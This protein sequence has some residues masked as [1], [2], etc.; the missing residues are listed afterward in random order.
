MVSLQTSAQAPCP[1]DMSLIPV[2][3]MRS[4]TTMTCL[5]LYSHQRYDCSIFPKILITEEVCTDICGVDRPS[6][7][8]YLWQ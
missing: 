1:V 8:Y 2:W 7:E 3:D 5:P 4:N 6:Q